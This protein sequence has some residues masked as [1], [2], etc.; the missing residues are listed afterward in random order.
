[1]RFVK[2]F[3][4]ETKENI[5]RKRAEKKI[6]KELYRNAAFKERK[7]QAEETAVYEEEMKAKSKKEH[8]K[9]GGNFGKLMKGFDNLSKNIADSPLMEGNPPKTRKQKTKSS[10]KR[11]SN[12]PS[13]DY[14]NDIVE[15]MVNFKI[16]G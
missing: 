15:D 5:K 16:G 6:I 4:E 8:I 12:S 9:E 13:R 10:T 14:S 2:D 11:N 7:K 1:M 3:M